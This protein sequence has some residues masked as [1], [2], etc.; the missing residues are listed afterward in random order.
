MINQDVKNALRDCMYELIDIQ[1]ILSSSLIQFNRIT[2][3]LTNYSTIRT[4]GTIEYSY[5]CLIADYFSEGQSEYIFNFLSTRIRERSINPQIGII[6]EMLNYFDKK[7]NEKFK[8]LL[9]DEPDNERKKSSLRSLALERNKM[10]HG[11]SS[12]I[13]LSDILN[14]FKDAR[15]II[16]ILD[17]TLYCNENINLDIIFPQIL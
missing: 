12:T 11:S 4:C 6:H 3:Y 5:K 17:K 10:A 2:K 8:E 13:T 15:R 9:N 1:K 16:E 14:Y 7:I